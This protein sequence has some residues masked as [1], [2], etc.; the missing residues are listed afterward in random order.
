MEVKKAKPT[1]RWEATPAGSLYLPT[2]TRKIE[3]DG[4]TVETKAASSGN[5]GDGSSATVVTITMNKGLVAQGEN[6]ELTVVVL[7]DTGRDLLHKAVVQ[8]QKDLDKL[9]R[10]QED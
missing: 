9:Y 6:G 5:T 8:I 10:L 4:V 3:A 1:L 7:G 2:C